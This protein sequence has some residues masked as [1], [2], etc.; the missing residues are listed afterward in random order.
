MVNISKSKIIKYKNNKYLHYFLQI[1]FKNKKIIKCALNKVSL[2]LDFRR[3]RIILIINLNKININVH[4]TD[5][6]IRRVIMINDY[7]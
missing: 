3:L 5:I 4:I 2:Y 1:T 6:I 7:C